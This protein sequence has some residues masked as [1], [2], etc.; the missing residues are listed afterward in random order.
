LLALPGGPKAAR[1]CLDSVLGLLPV[2]MRWS[3]EMVQDC[4]S[5]DDW[6]DWL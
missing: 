3:G 2:A 1:T 4:K 5:Q 6:F